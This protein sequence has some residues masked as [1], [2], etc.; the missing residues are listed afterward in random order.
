MK[1]KLD[2]NL[3]AELLDDP[4]AAG[5]EGTSVPGEGLPGLKT[6]CS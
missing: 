4:R 3:P 1:F 6:L 5:H 2:E